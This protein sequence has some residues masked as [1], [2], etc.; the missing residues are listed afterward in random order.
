VPVRSDHPGAPPVNKPIEAGDRSPI[1]RLHAG[2]HK[3]AFDLH[4]EYL[5]FKKELRSDYQISYSMSFPLA[6][7][8][9]QT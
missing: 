3:D 9:T 7:N 4:D 2:R 5:K 1:G 6:Q 8:A